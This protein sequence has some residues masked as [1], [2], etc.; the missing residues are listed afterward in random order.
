MSTAGDEGSL[1]GAE[2]LFVGGSLSKHIGSVSQ[3]MDST[4]CYV[5]C[6]RQRRRFVG[7]PDNF[8]VTHVRLAPKKKKTLCVSFLP[9][10]VSLIQPRAPKNFCF[11]PE[12]VPWWAAF[13]DSS[14]G[15]ICPVAAATQFLIH[16]NCC[17]YSV[18]QVATSVPRPMDRTPIQSQVCSSPAGPS[19]LSDP[20]QCK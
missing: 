8:H 7:R 16:H 14:I 9:L 6:L 10:S 3:S 11:C 17:C 12:P 13:I 20:A 1:Q 5:C 19:G 18:A 2:T 15:G 4:W